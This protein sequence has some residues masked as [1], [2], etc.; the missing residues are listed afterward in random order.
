[1]CS[2]AALLQAIWTCH[3]ETWTFFKAPRVFGRKMCLS[4]LN[5]RHASQEGPY[6]VPSSLHTSGHQHPPT[7]KTECRA[8]KE[9]SKAR[10]RQSRSHG[11]HS[12][13][14]AFQHSSRAQ[15]RIRLRKLKNSS[16]SSA[17]TRRRCS[18]V[19]RAC[20]TCHR[21]SCPKAPHL[22]RL[23]RQG[24]AS[25]QRGTSVSLCGRQSQME[26]TPV[27]TQHVLHPSTHEHYWKA[28]H[29]GPGHCTSRRESQVTGRTDRRQPA[30]K[31]VDS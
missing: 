13:D 10:E 23:I 30:C 2:F 28:S 6:G 22:K 5:K 8:V 7:E 25:K 14:M 12:R 1:M 16:P 20:H 3:E 27:G 4:P 15:N 11:F 17:W 31:N 21:Q 26:K 19:G 29:F 24:R 9:K 18:L